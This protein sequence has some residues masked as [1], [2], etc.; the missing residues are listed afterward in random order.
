MC[1]DLATV[2]PNPCPLWGSA[3]RCCCSKP[4]VHGRIAAALLICHCWA[5]IHPRWHPTHCHWVGFT[6]VGHG[7]SLL[8]W[9]RPHWSPLIVFGCDR[10]LLGW[11]HLCWSPLI[12]VGWDLLLLLS[13]LSLPP[14][15]HRCV[16]WWMVKNEP[17]H[18]SWFML[19]NSLGHPTSWVPSHLYPPSLS[20]FSSSLPLPHHGVTL[21][22]CPSSS[23]LSWHSMDHKNKP[24][25]M[26][27]PVFRNSPLGPP[28]SCVSPCPPPSLS[29]E[30]IQAAHI[31]LERG[32]A[33]VSS[34]LL[35]KLK[36][37]WLSPHPSME[38]R[39]HRQVGDEFGG[40]KGVGE[41]K[42]VGGEMIVL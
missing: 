13:S 4:V 1:L 15:P 29:V 9:I 32:G 42:M 34:S 6:V 35:R 11:I 10:P 21:W 40:I 23:P 20:S 8:G 2:C 12:I 38:G 18:L 39:A 16:T 41:G 33:A 31:P 28:T 19:H 36:R 3:C 14:S 17:Q 25:Q 7:S 26:S 24:W 27:W 30:W 22:V 5:G 37:S